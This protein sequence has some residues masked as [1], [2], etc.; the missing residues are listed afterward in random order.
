MAGIS[1]YG[2]FGLN[3]VLLLLVSRV[4]C[5]TLNYS[6]DQRQN[7]QVNVQIDM[8]DVQIVALMD[9]KM[10]DDYTNYD[11]IYDYADFTIKPT[12]GKPTS[13]PPLKPSTNMPN[14]LTDL[15]SLWAT[16]ATTSSS[17][18]ANLNQESSSTQTPTASTSSNT[19][20]I[21]SNNVTIEEFTPTTVKI[22]TTKMVVSNESSEA[23][24]LNNNVD[25]QPSNDS[26]HSDISKFLSLIG[27]DLTDERD[28]PQAIK[29]SQAR[30]RLENKNESSSG[31]TNVNISMDVN[32]NATTTSGPDDVNSVAPVNI[33][34]VS[35]ESR[36]RC[37]VGF[38]PRAG[39]CF[40]RRH[41]FIS[42]RKVFMKLSPMFLNKSK[43]LPANPEVTDKI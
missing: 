23:T 16:S 29:I 19:L 11:Y 21:T 7:G 38:V 39:K 28:K 10:L 5:K 42:P 12:S 43:E 41:S 3:L 34:P 25:Q 30:N 37:P 15:I 24:T 6:F 14:S 1:N 26:E 17:S 27:L 36:R 4:E 8:K 35:G 22:S 40:K 31:S 33:Q 20:N 13:K 18:T 9:S 2:A 32:F